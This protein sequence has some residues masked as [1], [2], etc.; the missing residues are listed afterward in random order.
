VLC[1]HQQYSGDH[2]QDSTTLIRRLCIEGRKLVDN[3]VEGQ[4]LDSRL[5]SIGVWGNA[6][7]PSL[8]LTHR[9]L[10][11][12]ARDTLDRRGFEREH[13]II[14]LHGRSRISRAAPADG[15]K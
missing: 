7:F 11:N 14:A 1:T 12:D 5:V 6:G 2:Y 3:F 15:A 10:L 9:E 13:G 8:S 4:G